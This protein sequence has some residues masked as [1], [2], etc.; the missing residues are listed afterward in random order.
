MPLPSSSVVSTVREHVHFKA[1]TAACRISICPRLFYGEAPIVSYSLILFLLT[2]WYSGSLDYYDSADKFLSRSTHKHNAE[3]WAPSM[4]PIIN[5][6]LS[7]TMPN[8]KSVLIDIAAT[9]ETKLTI[10]ANVAPAM[11]FQVL[12]QAACVRLLLSAHLEWSLHVSIKPLRIAYSNWTV[13]LTP[14]LTT[15]HATAH[16]LWYINP[17]HL[18]CALLHCARHAALTH[19]THRKCGRGQRHSFGCGPT[20]APRRAARAQHRGGHGNRGNHA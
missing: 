18:P 3:D 16:G 19:G 4:L 9:D 13:T 14:D 7:Q 11:F 1:P 20:G 5:L 6:V 12:S 8:T 10:V 17:L 2:C 15:Q